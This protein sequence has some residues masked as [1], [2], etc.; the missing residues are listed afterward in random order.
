M[1]GDIGEWITLPQG[2]DQFAQAS[3]LDRLERKIVAAFEFDADGK[4]VA[5]RSPFPERGARMPRPVVARDELDQLAVAPDEEMR[6]DLQG[7]DSGEVGMARRVQPVGEEVKDVVA[8]ELARRQADGMDH[9]QPGR[10]AGRP[11]IEVRRRLAP[12]RR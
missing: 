4:V 7:A 11:G 9:D 8:A 6:R 10:F 1:P 5:T 2:L 12:R 3:V